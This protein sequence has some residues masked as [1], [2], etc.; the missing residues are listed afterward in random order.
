MPSILTYDTQS[1]NKYIYSNSR[2][3]RPESG[4]LALQLLF[5]HVIT[6]RPL[7]KQCHQIIQEV[8][9]LAAFVCL[10]RIINKQLCDICYSHA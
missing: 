1:Y 8:L 6:E 10:L 5:V 7:N 3:N 9:K 2:L 4:L